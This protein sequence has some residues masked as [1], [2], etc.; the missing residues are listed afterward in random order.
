MNIIIEEILYKTIVVKIIGWQSSL[1]DQKVHIVIVIE[2][3]L[4]QPHTY[5]TAV[6]NHHIYTY[7]PSV[8]CPIWPHKGPRKHAT[9]KSWTSQ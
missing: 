9:C 2:A 5:R 3:S 1:V 6:Q 7:R 8:H 4:S